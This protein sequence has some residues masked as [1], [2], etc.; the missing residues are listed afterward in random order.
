MKVKNKGLFGKVQESYEYWAELFKLEF[1]DDITA[2][3]EKQGISQKGLADKMGNSEAYISKVLN[4]YANLSINSISKI[5]LA[6][7]AAP[8]I[9]VS[10]KEKIIEWKERDSYKSQP[11]VVFESALNISSDNIMY[12]TDLEEDTPDRYTERFKIQ[13]ATEALNCWDEAGVSSY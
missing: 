11:E 9:H 10:P 7:N 2:L 5:A 13:H 12:I 3:M 6:L 8:H 1:I 4:G